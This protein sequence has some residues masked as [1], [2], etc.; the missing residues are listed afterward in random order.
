MHLYEALAGRVGEWR[1]KQYAHE[2]YPAIAEILE[3]TRSPDVSSFRLRTPQVRALE[4]YWYLRLVEKT[5]HIFDL[6]KSLYPTVSERMAALG[7]DAPD[8]KNLALDV[9]FDGVVDK[10]FDNLPPTT[11]AEMETLLDVLD[12]IRE[13]MAVKTAAELSLEKA[14]P[15][16]P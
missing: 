10:V 9:G 7:M 14:K 3:W 5:P 16:R 11:N 12:R 4:T 13:H 1:Q 6:Y 8:L 2:A 15:G